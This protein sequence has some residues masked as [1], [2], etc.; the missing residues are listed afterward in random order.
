MPQQL[1]S[2]KRKDSEAPRLSKVGSVG[3]PIEQFPE[4]AR[5]S[6]AKFDADGAR[7]AMTR[8]SRRDARAMIL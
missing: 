4:R 5:A 7:R 1:L 2:Q 8:N 6:L 3:I